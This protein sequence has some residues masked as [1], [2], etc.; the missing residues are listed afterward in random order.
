MEGHV[1]EE[2][3]DRLLDEIRRIDSLMADEIERV[4][5]ERDGL[6][7]IGKRIIKSYKLAFE[8]TGICI[9]GVGELEREID[10]IEGAGE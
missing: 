3:A 10:K 1:R 7:K 2:E 6:I 9:N 8:Y 5:K 4:E